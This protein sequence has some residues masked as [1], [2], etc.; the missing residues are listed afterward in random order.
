MKWGFWSVRVC[1]LVLL[2]TLAVVGIYQYRNDLGAMMG[3]SLILACSSW[4][5]GYAFLGYLV[6]EKEGALK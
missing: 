6:F 5:S 4:L 1:L 3:F 2:S